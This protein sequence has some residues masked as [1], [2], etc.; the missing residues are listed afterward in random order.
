MPGNVGVS[1]GYAAQAAPA[2][3]QPGSGVFNVQQAA[4]TAVA[5]SADGAPTYDA[6]GLPSNLGQQRIYVGYL[7]PQYNQTAGHR[8]QNGDEA[9]VAYTDG[10]IANQTVSVDDLLNH[11][12]DQAKAP[13]AYSRATWAQVQ[14]QLQA[15]NAYGSSAR[16]NY[17]AWGPDDAAALKKAA[18]AYL[19]GTDAGKLE[20]FEEYLSQAAAQGAAN[21]LDA[22]QPGGPGT[23]KSKA[24]LTNPALISQQAD[25]MSQQFLGHGMD[26]QATGNV[27]GDVQ[28]Q[29]QAASDAGDIYMRSVTPQSVAR[30]YILQNN[31]PEY[32]QHQAES[33][34]NVFANMFLS[35]NSA[36]GNTTLGDAAVGVTK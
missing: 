2:P 21:N 29:E 18:N 12:A 4:A 23:G 15:I 35:G 28:G 24:V 30:E 34:M 5:T 22:N 1:G 16:I 20:T 14:Q 25:A 3:S 27:V 7:P 13:N 9:G 36:R 6:L 33:Y 10:G 8:R 19:Q 11:F 26:A 32:A 31:M 17:G